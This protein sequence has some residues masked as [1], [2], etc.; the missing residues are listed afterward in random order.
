MLN[1]V[2]RRWLKRRAKRAGLLVFGVLLGGW[3]LIN[4][5]MLRSAAS[6][7]VDAFLVLGGSIQREI[8]V[9]ELARQHPETPILI[10]TGSPVPCVWLIFQRANAPIQKV[11]LENC[12][13]STFD[14]FFFGLPVLQHWQTRK[15]QLITSPTHLPRA[16]WMAKI[17]LGAHGIWVEPDIV[18][19]TGTPANREFWWKT[20]LDVTRSLVWAAVSQ[21]YRPSCSSLYPL[22]A[23]D[24]QQW[25]HHNFHCERQGHLE[26]QLLK[27]Q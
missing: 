4:S 10:S 27:T 13:H 7:P 21:V 25:Q 15:V 11:W 12:A 20:G 17:L 24:M 19:E 22:A 3:L 9:A 1:R 23:I 18:V 8:H 5:A 16:V 14:N 6:Q 2:Q 26:N